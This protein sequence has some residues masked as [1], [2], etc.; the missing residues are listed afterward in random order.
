MRLV[1][2]ILVSVVAVSGAWGSEPSVGAMWELRMLGA[3]DEAKLAE[4]RD[5]PKKRRV[6]LGVVGQEGVSGK[7]LGE[8]L[9][10]GNTIA[11]HECED[12]A[13]S[14]H[15]TGQLRVVLD[16][17]SALGVETG[18]QLVFTPRSSC[19]LNPRRIQAPR[20]SRRRLPPCLP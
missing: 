14:T 2:A 1:L 5:A 15:D 20:R 13:R 4:L 16:L 19:R 11:Y 8:L 7:G 12:P 17:T 9:G 18:T 10:N 6:R 3:D